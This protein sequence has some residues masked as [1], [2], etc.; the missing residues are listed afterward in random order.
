MDDGV[1]A[2]AIKEMR[3]RRIGDLVTIAFSL[4]VLAGVATERERP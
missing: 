1:D 4:L 3:R 2:I